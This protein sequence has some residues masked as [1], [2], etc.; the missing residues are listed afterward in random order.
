MTQLTQNV[1]T[2]IFLLSSGLGTLHADN[3]VQHP[4][5]QALA[6]VNPTC[7]DCHDERLTTDSKE[8]QLSPMTFREDGLVMCESCHEGNSGHMVGVQITFASPPDLPLDADNRVTC[9]TC[10]YTHGNLSS[11]QPM[12]SFSVLDRMFNPQHLQKSY[13]LRRGNVNGELCLS[14]H[15][16]Y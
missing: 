12:A 15:E 9:V 14:C 13:L 11:L 4:H 1:L 5:H 6:K 10:H 7:L 2:F 8:L 3:V 16:L